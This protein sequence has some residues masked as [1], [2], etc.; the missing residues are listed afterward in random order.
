MTYNLLQ[1]LFSKQFAIWIAYEL[2]ILNLQTSQIVSELKTPNS[3]IFVEVQVQHFDITTEYY[4][5]YHTYIRVVVGLF[6]PTDQIMSGEKCR[7]A[8]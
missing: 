8:P 1:I 7:W 2:A 3:V 6:G 5:M 4:C